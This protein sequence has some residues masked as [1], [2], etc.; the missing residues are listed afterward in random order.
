MIKANTYIN[1]LADL[2]NNSKPPAA[3][4]K[5]KVSRRSTLHAGRPN[6]NNKYKNEQLLNTPVKV[7]AVRANDFEDIIRD[8]LL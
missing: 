3:P 7:I 1:I 2:V 8:I 4:V 5:K 6:T